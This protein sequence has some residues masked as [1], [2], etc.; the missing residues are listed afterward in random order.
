MVDGRA[1]KHAGGDGWVGM[2]AGGRLGGSVGKR[3]ET[4]GADSCFT[5]IFIVITA[6][7]GVDDQLPTLNDPFVRLAHPARPP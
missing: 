1:G 4:D 2:I 7:C 6:L 3:Q 5:R